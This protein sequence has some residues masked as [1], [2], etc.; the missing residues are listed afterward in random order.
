[1]AAISWPRIMRALLELLRA[2]FPAISF[3]EAPAFSWSSQERTIFF[4]D[5]TEHAS[6]SL[7]HEMG[8]MLANHNSYDSDIELL[9]M[10]AEAWQ[11]AKQVARKYNHAID[12]DHIE[13]CL[14]S[15]R[16]WLHQRSTCTVCAQ[17]GLERN[18]GCY[19]CINCGHGWQVG[20]DRF[21]RVYRKKTESSVA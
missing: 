9:Q 20:H 17:A 11:A 5:S 8:H 13:Q 10:E 6:W 14:D 21:C 7:L 3:V 18:T 4:T 19:Q 16:D 12:D 1:M 15:Y 2:D